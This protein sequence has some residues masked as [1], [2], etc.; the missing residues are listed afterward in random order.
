MRRRSELFFGAEFGWV[1]FY[2]T[3]DWRSMLLSQDGD[4]EEGRRKICEA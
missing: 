3:H 1:E 4:L 2:G